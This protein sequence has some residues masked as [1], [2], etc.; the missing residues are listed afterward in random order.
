[1]KE[2]GTVFPPS[3]CT[4]CGACLNACRAQAI[5]MIPDEEGFLFPHIDKEKCFQCGKCVRICPINSRAVRNGDDAEV[6]A[7]WNLNEEIREESSSGGAFSALATSI[8]KADGVVFGAAYDP[9]PKVKHIMIEKET[10]LFRLRGSKYVQSDTAWSFRRACEMLQQGR[11]VLFV[12]APCQIHGLKNYLGKEYENLLTCDFICHGVP[13]PSFFKSYAVFLCGKDISDA[14]YLNFRCKRSGWYD[15]LRTVEFNSRKQLWVRGKR[16]YYFRGF[17]LNLSL[18][19]SCY[20]C[21]EVGLARLS[22][23]TLGDFWG[24]GRIEKLPQRKEIPRGISLIIVHNKKARNFLFSCSGSLQI[25]RR[26]L[27]EALRANQP[28]IKPPLRPSGRDA[29]YA[30]FKNLKFNDFYHKYLHGSIKMNLT[31]V[32]REY[33]PRFIILWIRKLIRNI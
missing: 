15:A 18:R 16:D 31:A 30:D 19:E 25:H 20:Q 21:T 9:F 6:F 14:S 29:F 24:I 4:G 17:N 10:E 2:S 5:E 11:L 27:Q 3:N 1:M 28:L 7:A 12:G 26:T 33:L 13:S 23:I 22:D 8:L 32:G